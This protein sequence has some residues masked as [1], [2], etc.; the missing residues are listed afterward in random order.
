MNG[1]ISQIWLT[2]CQL[3]R[4]VRVFHDV[5]QPYP[6]LHLRPQGLEGPTDPSSTCENERIDIITIY[7]IIICYVVWK[8]QGLLVKNH[9]NEISDKKN[10]TIPVILIHQPK[11]TEFWNRFLALKFMHIFF[12]SQ[13]LLPNAKNSKNNNILVTRRFLRSFSMC[14]ACPSS[15]QHN[16]YQHRLIDASR[17]N[18]MHL[19]PS[20]GNNGV[21]I[22]AH[23]CILKNGFERRFFSKI[24]WREMHLVI[25]V[26]TRNLRG[27]EEVPRGR[28][29]WW[30]GRLSC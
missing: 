14:S 8:G 6:R 30:Q 2:C 28:R 16:I 18:H 29:R 9:L 12:T 24:W 22:Y 1:E 21:Q 10:Q 17:I 23:S 25:Y 4:I 20:T 19:I 26:A 5:V 13:R 27:T 11:P 15:N 7:G 3:L